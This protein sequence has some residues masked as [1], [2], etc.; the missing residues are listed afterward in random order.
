[1]LATS[2][3]VVIA[4]VAEFQR[5]LHQIKQDGPLNLQVMLIFP[6]HAVSLCAKLYEK[7]R[8]SKDYSE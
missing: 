2:D 8:S 7:P 1:M 3:T 6:V 4:N 5:K